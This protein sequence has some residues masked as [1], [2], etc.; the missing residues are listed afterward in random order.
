M[1]ASPDGCITTT[2]TTTTPTL[3]QQCTT[4]PSTAGTEDCVVST[5][6]SGNG[7]NGSVGGGGSNNKGNSTPTALLKAAIVS[8][9]DSTIITSLYQEK[10]DEHPM[11]QRKESG[12]S[13]TDFETQSR[14]SQ[15]SPSPSPLPCCLQTQV[16]DKVSQQEVSNTSPITNQCNG[17]VKEDLGCED[18]QSP[19]TYTVS[20]QKSQQHMQ[21]NQLSEMS[22]NVPCA[23]NFGAS[24]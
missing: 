6:P 5:F 9:N 22:D 16:I 1:T 11:C 12:S 18:E 10:S 20:L 3:S 4:F 19:N 14:K 2:A 24:D 15:R 17:G 8:P 7:S 21:S 23:S 13:R